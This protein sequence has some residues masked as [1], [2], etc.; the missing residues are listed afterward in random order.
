MTTTTTP[1]EVASDR[2]HHRVMAELAQQDRRQA[3]REAAA[4]LE[5]D[6][7]R[8]REAYYIAQHGIEIRDDE[9]A[10]SAELLEVARRRAA[11]YAAAEAILREAIGAAVRVH[12]PSGMSVA[13]AAA[14]A[15]ADAHIAQV[16]PAPIG[17]AQVSAATRAEGAAAAACSD[18]PPPPPR[19]PPQNR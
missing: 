1:P 19:P 7:Q 13:M 9:I 14:L 15:A 3:A 12:G 11:A 6:R 16:P 8:A 17:V 18:P 5:E 2:D 4:F 10:R